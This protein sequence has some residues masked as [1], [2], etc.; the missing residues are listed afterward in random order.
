MSTGTVWKVALGV[1]LGG[2]AVVGTTA[3]CLM[4]MG[5]LALRHQQTQGDALARDFIRNV[6]RATP[7]TLLGQ[8][9]NSPAVPAGHR[10]IGNQLFKR[11]ENGWVQVSSTCTP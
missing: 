8:S 6:D 4:A 2:M 1:Y 3:L 7:R 9:T 5:Q 11:V 10:C